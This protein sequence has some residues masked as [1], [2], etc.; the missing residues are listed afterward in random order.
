MSPAVQAALRRLWWSLLISSVFAFAVSEVSYQLVKD[1]SERPPQVV[2]ILIPAGT[3][4]Q[5]ANGE[6]GPALPEMKFVEG[7]TLVVRN[8]D[9]VSH[10]LGPLWVLPG[11]SSRMTLDRPSQYTME[12]SFQQTRSLGIDVLARAKASDRVFGI[13]SIGF[14]TWILLWLYTLVVK[15]L[16]GSEN[17]HAVSEAG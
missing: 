9:D 14:P 4:Q 7:D 11:S 17:E 1:Q 12:C 8:L 2:E 16:P 15:P 13:I 10:Q 3:A 5:I 6:N